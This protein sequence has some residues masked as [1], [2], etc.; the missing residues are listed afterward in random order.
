[1]QGAKLMGL[2]SGRKQTTR[3]YPAA[4]TSVTGSASR[5]FRA[6]TVGAR[7]AAQQGQDWEDQ[8]R[9]QDRKGG[10]YRYRPSR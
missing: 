5:F 4:G 6:K 7:R 9:R 10:F 8:D 2:F 1:M 3:A